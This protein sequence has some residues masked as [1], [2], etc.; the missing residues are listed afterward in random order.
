MKI[1]KGFIRKNDSATVTVGY[2]T[3]E[4]CPNCK[5]ALVPQNLYG[6]VHAR[7]EK[8]FL[9]VADYCNGCHSLIV[10]EY[11]ISKKVRRTN[12]NGELEYED[13]LY[14]MVKINHS[15]PVNFKEREFDDKLK[16][17]S[18][19]FVKIY[20]QAMKAE[21]YSLDEIAGLGYRKSLEFLIKDFAIYNNPDKAEEIKS[22]WMM[23]CLKDYIDN[24]KIKTLAEKSEWIGND[25]AHYVKI[26]NDR[27]INDMK[28]F[29][30]ALVYF[31]S[32]SLIVDD[33]ETMKSKKENA[34]NE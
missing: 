25:E 4:E 12:Q 28:K 22:T 30:D 17:V 24:D 31:I 9:S 10:S 11:E 21:E 34:T 2:E 13:K 7:C 8:E 27:D 1:S 15:A 20:N 29:I 3:I 26:Q 16:E 5:K 32:M 23:K 18:P 6:I 33:A 14:K 19:Q